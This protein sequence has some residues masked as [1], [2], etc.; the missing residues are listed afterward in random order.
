MI[1]QHPRAYAFPEVNLF[2]YETLG[3]FMAYATL[4]RRFLAHGLLRTV[5]QLYAGEQT[6]ETIAMAERWIKRRLHLSSTEVYQQL[7]GQVA[8]RRVADKSPV[9]SKKTQALTRIESSFPGTHYLYLVRNPIEQGHS[10]LRA[11]QGFTELLGN[12]SLDF[13][14]QPPRLEP[15]YEWYKTQIRILE[16]LQGIPD[17]RKHVLRGELLMSEPMQQLAAL[18]SWLDLEWSS[19]IGEE[20]LHPERSPYACT[21]PFGANSGNNPGFQRSPHFRASSNE[22]RQLTEFL[23]WR[24]DQV[25][26]KPEVRELAESFGYV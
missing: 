26:L 25:T 5:A 10:M 3:E 4:Q 20:M 7:A 2:A 8:P 18:C 9:Y 22:A 21:G 6:P 1:G 23:P 11:Q 24:E 16:F 14:F 17:K 12:R 13:S 15:Q 19:E